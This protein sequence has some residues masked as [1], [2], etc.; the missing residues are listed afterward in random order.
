MC[1]LILARDVLGP[2]T[3]LIGANR[4]ERSSRPSAPPGVLRSE[5]RVVGGMDRQAGGTWLAVRE[6]RAGVKEWRFIAL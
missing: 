4:D 6:G 3:I 2:R 1:T 5:P